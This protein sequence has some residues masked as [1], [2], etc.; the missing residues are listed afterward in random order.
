MTEALDW[1]RI[2]LFIGA[3]IG[4]FLIG[5]GVFFVCNALAST[6]ARLGGI[7]GNLE[8]VADGVTK[9]TSLATNAVSPALVNLGAV[10]TGITAGLRRLVAGRNGAHA[11][12]PT[13]GVAP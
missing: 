10:L 1:P 8:T 5:L 4:V 9:T 12:D 6:I 2:I 7:V 13:E 3:G 11:S